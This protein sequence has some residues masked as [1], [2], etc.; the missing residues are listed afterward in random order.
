MLH[1]ALLCTSRPY[2]HL[3]LPAIFH[4]IKN[5]E[6]GTM[7]YLS[8]QGLQNW[9]FKC[10]RWNSQDA[11]NKIRTQL[12]RKLFSRISKIA[13][14][15]R[16]KHSPRSVYNSLASRDRIP[17]PFLTTWHKNLLPLSWLSLGITLQFDMN[18]SN[19]IEREIPSLKILQTRALGAA[20][21]GLN[22]WFFMESNYRPQLY[23]YHVLLHLSVLGQVIHAHNQPSLQKFLRSLSKRLHVRR[24]SFHI[25]STKCKTARLYIHCFKIPMLI[26]PK[27]SLSESSTARN[28]LTKHGLLIYLWYYRIIS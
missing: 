13:H 18:I 4:D 17:L 8:L 27:H 3:T 24:R 10:I 23:S 25:H 19:F 7:L 14:T 16:M 9:P 26:S 6:K 22:L 12:H 15:K 20:Q 5:Q 11:M 28:L 2:H 1:S 21:F